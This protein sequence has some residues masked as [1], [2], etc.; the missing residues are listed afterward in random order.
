ML[1]KRLKKMWALIRREGF[2]SA[3]H[4]FY[5]IIGY[6]L[7]KRFLRFLNGWQNLL[8]PGWRLRHQHRLAR[9]PR[10][11]TGP[12][13]SIYL[14]GTGPGVA[15]TL[16]SL[17]R[18]TY[19][20]WEAWVSSPALPFQD[21]RIHLISDDLPIFKGQFT[22]W[23]KPGDALAPAALNRLAAVI[24]Q[25]DADVFY[26]DE[27]IPAP[28]G[29]WQPLF[30][31]DFSPELLLSTNYLQGAFI[32]ASLFQQHFSDIE[33]FTWR[34]VENKARIHHLPELLYRRGA[35]QKPAER[36]PAITDHL[37][38]LG[39]QQVKV[40]MA[41]GQIQATWAT[42]RSVTMIIPTRNNLALLRRCIDSL[43][44]KTRYPNFEVILVDNAST[45]PA[46][47]AYY[48]RITVEKKVRVL[49]YTDAFNFSLYC[50]RGAAQSERDVVLFLNNDVEIIDPGWLEQMMQWFEL[51]ETGMVG[52][53]LLYPDGTIQHAGVVIGMEGH[54]GHIFNGLPEGSSGAF[55]SVD[56]YRNYLTQTAACMA[57]RR[58]LFAQV[59]GFDERY[60]LVFND[61]HL[62]L[63]VVEA[64]YRV[65]HTP[66][67]R[68]IHYEGKSRAKYN[69]PEDIR[70][71]CEHARAW[72]QRGDPFFNPNL[73]YIVSTPMIR[74]LP[75]ESPLRKLEKI[76]RFF[77]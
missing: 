1:L 5:S 19:P 55:G 44:A 2:F 57:L 68:L 38:R 43:F 28:G 10:V 66:F 41:A 63:K 56:W 62:G 36:I 4:L 29:G 32:R 24:L 76:T 60:Q 59:G 49:K 53:R 37:T 61:M 26:F 34:L 75:E 42:A 65:I 20:N 27:E 12:L 23:L 18:Q 15:I 71:G 51:P 17:R 77:G 47:F 14:P 72:A 52:A 13:F 16:T 74:W 70:L 46:V 64:G 6:G 39:L 21:Q 8:F 50:N 73:S 67:A 45:D 40:G 31:P 35:L 48:D 69:P 11:K 7:H 22:A 25:E 58:N 9:L 33:T 30:K 54:A 3:V